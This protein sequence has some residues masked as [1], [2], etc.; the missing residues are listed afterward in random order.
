VRTG[1]LVANLIGESA[2]LDE[3]AFAL[4]AL[5]H[6]AADSVGHPFINRATA[7]YFPDLRAKYG[8]SVTF[9]DCCHAHTQTEYGFDITEVA[10][11]RFTSDRYHDFIGFE[12]SIPLLER[13]VVRTYGLRL[14]E[15]LGHVELAIGTFRRAVSE[16]IPEMNRAALTIYHPE[17]VKDPHGA[18]ERLFLYNLSR[19]QY[20]R[21]WGTD[22]RRPGF[23]TRVL[24]F[25]LRLVPKVGV[26]KAFNFPRP[27][28][29]TEALYVKSLDLTLADCR[30]LLAQ[31]G[32]GNLSF[33]NLDCD[34]GRPCAPGEYRLTDK[35]YRHLLKL[36]VEDGQE[37]VQPDLRANIL[38]FYAD[39]DPVE[40]THKQ[41]EAWQLTVRE[42]EALRAGPGSPIPA[43]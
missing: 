7:I 29:Q 17:S 3:Y 37:T 8:D 2:N 10:K 30:R 39:A 38:A 19:A 40:R 35:S 11:N 23:F 5:T 32:E 15:T 42:L 34:T 27:T 31:V 33:P 14:D 20:E 6:Y 22:Y 28:P 12:V 9:A 36:L 1:D 24:G 25:L 21:E 16:V 43:E 18:S 13:A 26:F 41:R 4:G